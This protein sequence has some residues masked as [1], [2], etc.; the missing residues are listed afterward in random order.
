VDPA[1]LQMFRPDSQVE[2][3]VAGAIEYARVNAPP[4]AT[5]LICG[6]LYLIG[7]ARAMLQ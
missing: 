7:E 5:I 3:S 6:S 4:A 2:A 1:E